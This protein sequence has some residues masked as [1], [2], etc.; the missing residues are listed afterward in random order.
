LIR[1]H[2]ETHLCDSDQTPLQSILQKEL[3]E[4]Q[5]R[6][7]ILALS[8][9]LGYGKGQFVKHFIRHDAKNWTHTGL[10]R[11]ATEIRKAIQ[12]ICK[13]HFAENHRPTTELCRTSLSD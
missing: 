11:R 2:N 6:E 1:I 4:S 3:I 8:D 9:Q 7:L 5:R 12:D 13:T 10:D